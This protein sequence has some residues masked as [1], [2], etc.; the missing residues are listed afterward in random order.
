M[1]HKGFA[2]SPARLRMYRPCSSTARSRGAQRA[3]MVRQAPD[4]AAAAASSEQPLVPQTNLNFFFHPA[5]SS[6]VTTLSQFRSM[7]ITT[8]IKKKKKKKR[9]WWNRIEHLTTKIVSA[10]FNPKQ[11]FFMF[12]S[13]RYLIT[14][15][16]N[17][18]HALCRAAVIQLSL[19]L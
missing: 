1:L 4:H 9:D 8:F 15:L 19:G 10:L 18:M 3:R 12:N 16:L 14:S 2:A 13:I 11:N 17:S 6:S 5:A 7:E